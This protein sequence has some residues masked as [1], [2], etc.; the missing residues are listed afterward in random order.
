MM[1]VRDLVSNIIKNGYDEDY[2]NQQVAKIVKKHKPTKYR[3]KTDIQQGFTLED[4]ILSYTATLDE[5]LD[6]FIA[7]EDYEICVDIKKSK[8]YII[9]EFERYQV[10]V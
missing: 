8:D 5:V 2:M 7:S 6:D 3:N 1:D 9:A 10:I 4:V